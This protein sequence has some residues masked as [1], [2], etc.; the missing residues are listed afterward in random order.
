MINNNTIT[1]NTE[2]L[3]TV[4][5]LQILYVVHPS[6]LKIYIV[7]TLQTGELLHTQ[8]PNVAPKTAKPLLVL[9]TSHVGVLLKYS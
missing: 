1:T 2:S 8:R 9:H 6:S 4:T 7:D 3:A 5:K